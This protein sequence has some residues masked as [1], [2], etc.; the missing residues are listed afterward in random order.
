MS[1]NLAS[2]ETNLKK[3]ENTIK[4][5]K[6]YLDYQQ[7]KVLVI[8]DNFIK[9]E[10]TKEVILDNEIKKDSLDNK[11]DIKIKKVRV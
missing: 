5:F 4:P 11:K 9:E 2:S 3:L 6:I 7:P 8:K 10:K 1:L